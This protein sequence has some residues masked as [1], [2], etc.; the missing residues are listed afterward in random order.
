MFRPFAAALVM[1]T[2]AASIGGC[3]STPQVSAASSPTPVQSSPTPATSPSSPRPSLPPP[4]EVTG[5]LL[6][7]L[8]GKGVKGEVKTGSGV[9]KTDKKGRFSLTGTCPGKITFKAKGYAPAPTR[10]ATSKS[11]KVELEADPATTFEQ[12]TAWRAAQQF[13]KDCALLHPDAHKY[14]SKAQCIKQEKDAAAAGYQDISI[15]IKSVTFIKWIHPRCSSA[16]FG[17]KTYPHTAAINY[18]VQQ[19]TPSGGVS[20]TNGIAHFVQTKDGL[21]RWFLVTANCQ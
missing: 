8:T 15:R 2:V 3:T 20:A 4:C 1:L 6:S 7:N 5:Q 10:V 18:T 16:D 12:M 19:T 14:V 9:V 17:P 11:L 13:A 21:W